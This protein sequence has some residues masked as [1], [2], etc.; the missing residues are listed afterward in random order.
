MVP[1][2]QRA[3]TPSVGHNREGSAQIGTSPQTSS[4][5]TEADGWLK[6]WLWSPWLLCRALL[7]DPPH[8]EESQPQTLCLSIEGR[9]ESCC[10]SWCCEV[11]RGRRPEAGCSGGPFPTFLLNW[12]DLSLWGPVQPCRVYFWED[13]S[14][15]WRPGLQFLVLE[16][17][18]GNGVTRT[19][20]FPHPK[21]SEELL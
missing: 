2:V 15:L 11:E 8:L 16:T 14:R 4:H 10:G 20:S 5:P 12:G 6:T 19:P 7:G 17:W 9:A 18:G 21:G 3:W 1:A 13:L